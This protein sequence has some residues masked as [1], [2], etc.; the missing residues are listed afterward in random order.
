MLIRNKDPRRPEDLSALNL[1]LRKMGWSLLSALGGR[2]LVRKL[3][4]EKTLCFFDAKQHPGVTGYVAFT[5]D[6]AFCGED[7]PGGSMLADVLEL[8]GEYGVRATFFVA[9]THCD[10]DSAKLIP[11]LLAAGHELANHNLED[12][13]YHLET[14]EDFLKDLD[15]TE[16]A[17]TDLG[18]KTAPWYRAP[19][20]KFSK[21]MQ[22]ALEERDLSHVMVDCFANDTAIPDPNFICQTILNS[23]CDGSIVLIHMPE[24]NMREWNLQAMRDT[25]SGIRQ[26]GL[27][28]VTVSELVAKARS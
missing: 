11:E 22:G 26:K 19:H 24:K 5:I 13:P 14:K 9:G 4:P 10:E 6:D 25:L 12:R 17:I 18:A 28:A 3:Y 8:L 21:A 20:A 7:N 23:V 1:S 16:A 2:R 27:Q 15:A